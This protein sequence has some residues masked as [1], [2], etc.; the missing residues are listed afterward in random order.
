MHFACSSLFT[1]T[2]FDSLGSLSVSLVKLF[3]K[4]L[5]IYVFH[6]RLQLSF[7]TPQSVLQTCRN[8]IY[9]QWLWNCALITYVISTRY[10]PLVISPTTTISTTT[11]FT[12]FLFGPILEF[13]I[14]TTGKTVI[15]K[16]FKAFQQISVDRI[17]MFVVVVCSGSMM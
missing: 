7:L 14:P 2:S 11:K 1:Y 10:A 13:M 5:F 17:V 4:N 15:R 12:I 9:T 3:N 6:H 16:A 8:F